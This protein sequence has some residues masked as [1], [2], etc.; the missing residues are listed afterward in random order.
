V[1]ERE[2][3]A[4]STEALRIEAQV[5]MSLLDQALH[6]QAWDG[7]GA[8][9]AGRVDST[10]VYHQ[11]Y[12]ESSLPDPPGTSWQGFFGHLVCYGATYYSYLFARALAGRV[13][14]GVFGGGQLACEREAGERLR[15]ELL[16]WG[17]GR[18]PWVCV[19]GLL[20][21]EELAE[22]GERAMAR[23]GEWG[24]RSMGEG[25]EF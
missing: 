10:A 8:G 16:R 17:G 11:V 23:V 20:G 18:D 3:A 24:V 25:S 13:W 2:Q 22:G 9:T 21:E 12:A 15:M 1:Q 4:G 5:M 6:A 7:D 19:A 14:R